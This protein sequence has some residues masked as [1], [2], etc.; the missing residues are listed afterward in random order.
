MRLRKLKDVLFTF[1][2]DTQIYVYDITNDDLVRYET[3]LSGF[4]FES[5]SE[6]SEFLPAIKYMEYYVLRVYREA[7]KMSDSGDVVNIY[8]SKDYDIGRRKLNGA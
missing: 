6:M 5:W 8:I 1:P 2:T 4:Y 7:I 3:V